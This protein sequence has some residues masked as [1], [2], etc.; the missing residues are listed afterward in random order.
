MLIYIWKA[1]ASFKIETFVWPLVLDRV[2]TIDMLSVAN[3]I[4]VFLMGV[5]ELL[6]TRFQDF[7]MEREIC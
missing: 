6:P 5:E 7:G 1:K 2:N 4:W 3:C